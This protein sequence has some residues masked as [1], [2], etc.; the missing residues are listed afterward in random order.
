MRLQSSRSLVRFVD[1]TQAREGS[2]PLNGMTPK[3]VYE[4][5]IIVLRRIQWT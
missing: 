4:T 3:Q 2:S 1:V 5:E